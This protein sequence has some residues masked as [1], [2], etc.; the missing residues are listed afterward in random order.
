M[1]KGVFLYSAEWD[2]GGYPANCPFN[3]H[4]AGMTRQT[5][6]GMGLLGGP[7]RLEVDPA[8][9]TEADLLKFHDPGYLSALQRAGEGE[10]PLE[11]YAMGLGTPDCPV[12]RG[13]YDYATRT[14]GGTVAGARLVAAGDAEVAF[15]PAGGYH[16]A[17]PDHAAGFCYLNDVVLGALTLA[18]AGARV[19]V[20]D[21]DVHHGDGT[22]N[23]FYERKDVMTISMHESGRTLFPGTGFEDEIGR[24]D[25][26][27][28]CVNVPLPVGT[29]DGAYEF[30]FREAVLP[31]LQAFQPD[32]IVLELGMDGLAG[33]P[34]AHL[35]L[36]NNVYADIVGQVVALGRPIVATGGGGYH[37]ENTVRGWSLCWSVLIGEQQDDQSIGMGGVML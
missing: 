33:D 30:A 17:G 31:L 10:L 21:L 32:A 11:A 23:A 26:R 18:E 16:H 3:S 2:R 12:F 29:Y 14:V 6:L 34:L 27:G 5:L 24:G 7:G 28:Y 8:A 35:N 37:V 13:L 20:L 1:R 25:G 15:N 4:R 9:A 19:L 36:T 22:Q